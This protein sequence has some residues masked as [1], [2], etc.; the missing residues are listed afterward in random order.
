M[1]L[2]RPILFLL[3]CT[4]SLAAA[5]QWQWIDKTGRKVYS[6]RAPPSDVP[7]A[8]I[9][10][11]PRNARSLA[12]NATAAAAAPLPGASGAASAPA[13][14]ASGLPRLSGKDT[15]LETKKKQAEQEEAARKQAADEKL[16]ADKAQNC[17]R[18]KNSLA[19]LNSGRRIQTS[20]KQGERE[21]M[22]DEAR[23][24]EVKVTQDVI[25]RDCGGPK[26]Q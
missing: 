8:S 23:A 1:K 10:K 21:V 22:T 15:E 9:V 13:R 14:A 11:Q 26:P 4:L 5:A 16:A 24:A 6:D 17:E 25:N 7:D 19:T 20:N 12:V 18:A 3:A 2:S